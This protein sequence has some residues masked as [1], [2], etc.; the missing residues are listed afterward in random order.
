[1]KTE[2]SH[3][4]LESCKKLNHMGNSQKKCFTY[5]C[6]CSKIQHIQWQPKSLRATTEDLWKW[7]GLSWGWKRLYFAPMWI[8]LV[9]TALGFHTKFKIYNPRHTLTP[10][11]AGPRIITASQIHIKDSIYLREKS[12]Q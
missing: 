4:I 2:F 9:S 6:V 10:K 12:V 11:H 3:E 1:M 7:S 5:L 8:L